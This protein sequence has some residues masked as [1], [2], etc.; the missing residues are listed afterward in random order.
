MNQTT[1]KLS[2]SE[3]LAWLDAIRGL[4][5]LNVVLCH[6]ADIYYPQ[7]N[8]VAY[9]ENA[10]G[11][12]S[13]FA[14][15]P[16]SVLVNGNIAVQYFFVLT[17][18]LVARSFFTKPITAGQIPTRSLNRYVRLLPVVVI[19][20]VFTHM[21][22]V[23]GLQHHFSIA[24]QVGHRDFLQQY[25]NFEPTVPVLLF[26]AL[27]DPFSHHGSAYIVPF[28]TITYEFWGY[29]VAMIICLLLRERKM[30]RLEYMIVALLFLREW[31]PVYIAFIMG[32]FVADLE[33]NE[34]ESVFPVFF[35]QW[36]RKKAVLAV[37]FVGGVYLACCPVEFTFVHAWLGMIPDITPELVRAAGVALLLFVLLNF[38]RVQTLLS[39]KPLVALG[40]ISFEVYAIHWP[41]MLSLQAWLFARMIQVWSYDLAAVMSFVLTIPVVYISAAAVHA[42]C[43][44]LSF[45]RKKAR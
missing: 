17:G 26:N 41:L 11:L 8:F 24:G 7:M 4:M 9:A 29:I 22:M 3:K 27:V 36:L 32:I 42:V 23:F 1:P 30:R 28:W 16:L 44:K 40:E 21:T 39:W 18:F 20:T 13:L 33:Y 15:T 12:L 38:S 5:A 14:L 25:C 35:G 37:L 34:H 45:R 19:A 6:F 31:D 2:Q 10:G 43:R